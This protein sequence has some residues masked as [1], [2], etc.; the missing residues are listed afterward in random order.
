MMTSLCPSKWGGRREESK[1]PVPGQLLGFGF[2]FRY[3]LD[4]VLEQ[5]AISRES[6]GTPSLGWV[7]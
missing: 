4:C 7:S 5:A 1:S 6:N 2:S 3:L